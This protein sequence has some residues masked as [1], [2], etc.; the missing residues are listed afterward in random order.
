ML[1]DNPSK[2]MT[3]QEL[4]RLAEASPFI[5]FRLHLADG[6]VLEVPHADFIHVFTQ[7]PRVV[8]ESEDGNWQLVNLP[9]VVSV[10]VLAGKSGN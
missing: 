2:T 1:S 9:I 10:E 4:R 8:I 7:A 3:T 5:P 6:R